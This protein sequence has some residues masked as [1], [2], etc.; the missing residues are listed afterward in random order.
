[1]FA[2]LIDLDQ[3]RALFLLEEWNIGRPGLGRP[4]LPLTSIKTYSDPEQL[5]A[6]YTAAR[7]ELTPTGRGPFEAR[8]VRLELDRLWV[9]RI[10]ESTPRI[11]CAAQSPERA[12]IRFQ[13]KPGAELVTN[14]IVLQHSELVYHSRAHC[15]CEFSSGPLHWAGVSLPAE[16]MAAMG[17]SVSGCDL[18]PPREA[19][20][21]SPSPETMTRLRRLH[22]EAGTL[23]ETDPGILETAEVAH[24]LEQLLIE[25]VVDCLGGHQAQRPT[26]ARSSQGTV[27]RRFRRVL[28]ED[29]ERAFYVPEICVA[30][31]VPERTLRFCCHE[32]LNMSPKQYLLLRRMHRVHRV[33][34]QSILG[35]TTVTGVAT[36]FGFWHFGR[37]ASTY[38]LIFGELPSV[39]LGRRTR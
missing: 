25:A 6:A 29:P 27:M 12:F 10:D 19:R 8:V 28:E 36:R 34:R 3:C 18:S 22:A 15:Y 20:H 37:F 38:R 21:L 13:T 9:Q 17:T 39:T 31:G 16:D 5:E 2:E 1:M 7:V 30:I 11:K 35:Q 4:R 14:G 24:G 32:Q 33:L 23:V 26:L